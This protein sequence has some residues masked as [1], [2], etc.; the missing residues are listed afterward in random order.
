MPIFRICQGELWVLELFARKLKNQGL[1]LKK[2]TGDLEHG[3]NNRQKVVSCLCSAAKDTW[4][5]TAR[6]VYNAYLGVVIDASLDLVLIDSYAHNFSS[7][8]AGNGPHRT[9]HAAPHIQ[10]LHT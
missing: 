8:G 3:G 5:A 7:A 10:S 4:F 1:D 6:L 9:P 2:E